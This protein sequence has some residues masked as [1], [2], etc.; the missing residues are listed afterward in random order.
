MQLTKCWKL[1]H[2]R[3][4]TGYFSLANSV[5]LMTK[6]VMSLVIRLN[7]LKQQVW[8]AYTV[9]HALD[10][11][12]YYVCCLCPAVFLAQ[13]FDGWFTSSTPLLLKPFMACTPDIFILF[14]ITTNLRY[15]F[16]SDLLAMINLWMFL[17]FTGRTEYRDRRSSSWKTRKGK[18]TIKGKGKP[19]RR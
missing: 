1:L 4:V 8:S 3:V 18:K 15:N 7:W 5:S 11:D 14:V 10:G 19:L 13:V 17:I 16:D 6:W 2:L 12:N 9:L